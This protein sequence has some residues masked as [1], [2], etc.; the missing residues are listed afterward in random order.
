MDQPGT[1][2]LWGRA[3]EA[4]HDLI[5]KDDW[6]AVAWRNLG[7]EGDDAVALWAVQQN[8]TLHQ[9]FVARRT[10]PAYRRP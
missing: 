6:E 9:A 3:C 1:C 7:I 2:L 8:K 10:G 5:E 4:C